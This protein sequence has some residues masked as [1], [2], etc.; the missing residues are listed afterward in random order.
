MP[1]QKYD[2][3]G[4]IHGHADKLEA[5]LR[6][7]GYAWIDGAYQHSE[8]R[9]VI[10]LGDFIDRGPNQRRVLQIVIPMI[11]LGSAQAVMGNHE[12]NAL[13]FH[14]PDPNNLGSWLRPRINKNIQQHLRFL[15]EYLTYPDELKGVLDF[16][17]ELPLWLDLGDFR[18]VHACW[19][20]SEI[21]CLVDGGLLKE[22]CLTDELLR[23]A[24]DKDTDEYKAIEILLKG[25]EYELPEECPPFLDKDGHDRYE[26]RAQWWGND[27]CKENN[28]CQLKDLAFPPGVLGEYAND[29]GYHTIPS[30]RIVNYDKSEKPVFVGHYWLAGQPNLQAPN[31]A[32]LDYSIANGGKLVA[33]S[34]NN[35]KALT[36]KNFVFVS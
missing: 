29:I 16:F 31:V 11:K 9:N 23:K 4:D 15:E 6:K 27:D 1:D 13:S 35:Q 32:C 5:L 19:A 14:T 34:W 30:D 28:D 18:V 33:Y 36:N 24:N 8:G 22:G 10:F 20:P 3:I 2:I 7:L 25:L 17:M 26:V 12:F 21:K